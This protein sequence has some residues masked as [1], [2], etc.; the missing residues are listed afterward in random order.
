MSHA[1]RSPSGSA[2]SIAVSIFAL[3]LAALIA[4]MV[5]FFLVTF[6]GPPPKDPPRSLE[7]IAS[8][9]RTGTPPHDPGPPLS[10]SDRPTAPTGQNRAHAGEVRLATILGVSADRVKIFAEPQPDD[11]GSAFVGDFAAGLRRGATWRIV[12]NPPRALITRWHLV[13]LGAMLGLVLLLA[14]PTWRIARALSRPLRQLADTAIHARAGVPLGTIPEGGASE[15]RDLS[16]AVAAMHHRLT[17]DAQGRTTMLAAIAHDV[18]TPLSRLAFRIEQLPDNSRTRALAD[19]EEM[20]AMLAAA[21]RFARDEASERADQRLD[22]GSLLDSLCEDMAATGAPVA[23][24]P[25]ARVI[26]RGDPAALRRMF[27]NL[28]ENAVR[29]GNT[30][31]VGWVLDLDTVTVTIDDHGPGFDAG[32]SLRLFEPFVR[33]DPSRNRDTGGTGLGLAIVRA[34]VEAHRGVVTLENHAGG[35]RVRVVLPRLQR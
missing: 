5:A 9:L 12:S 17:Q 20:R 33:G 13:T 19:I 25:G 26:V 29:Y 2:P 8:A 27:G 3:V 1:D 21:L 23:L 15:V 22:L 10:I 30:A 18:G 34:I 28:V 14:V 7:S 16:R 11:I 6:N 4:A 31:A 35:G 24:T 32:H